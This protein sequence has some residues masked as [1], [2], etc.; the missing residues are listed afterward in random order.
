MYLT[1]AL[2]TNIHLPSDAAS[3]DLMS[4]LRIGSLIWDTMDDR[5]MSRFRHVPCIL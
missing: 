1:M 3:K 5:S 4:P 2:C